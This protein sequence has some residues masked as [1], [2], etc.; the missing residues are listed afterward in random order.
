MN[1]RTLAFILFLTSF[2]LFIR[3]ANG[4]S[5]ETIQ[6][7]QSSFNSLADLNIKLS[8]DSTFK[9]AMRILETEDDPE[10]QLNFNGTWSENSKYYE[11][12]FIGERP[13]LNALFDLKY[14]EPDEFIIRNDSVIWFNRSKA[15]IMIWGIGCKKAY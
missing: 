6:E 9:F 14:A 13:I 11:L 2:Q 12:T 4:Q 5:A 7:Y 1:S 3:N 10:E 8:T 15:A